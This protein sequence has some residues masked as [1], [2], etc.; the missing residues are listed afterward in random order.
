MR[1]V[2][3][4]QHGTQWEGYGLLWFNQAPSSCLVRGALAH[5]SWCN[6]AEG[7]V[8]SAGRAKASARCACAQEL[9]KLLL[10][11]RLAGA[12]LLILANKQDIPGALS[13]SD[14]QKVQLAS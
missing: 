13:A 14:I 6:V 5:C 7:L 3:S 10:E 1:C 2:A 8:Y 11:E 4:G 9:H 12:T